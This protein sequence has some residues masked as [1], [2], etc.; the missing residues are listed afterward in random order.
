MA[1]ATSRPG[2]LIRALLLIAACAALSAAADAG[3][4]RVAVAANFTD[5]AT[6]IGRHFEAATGHRAVYSFGSTGQ[7][8]AQITQGAPFDVFMAADR[9]RPARLEDEGL[10][11]PGS[12][13]TYATGRL[14]LYSRDAGL[15]AGA[16]T[17]R[18]DA[19]SRLAVAN[20]ATAPYGAA[21]VAVMKALNVHG[22]LAGRIVQGTNIAQAYQFVAT[23][24][25]DAGFI[26]LSQVI[27][28]DRGSR[29]I[30]PEHLHAPIAQ[31]AV[32][33][34]HGL[35]SPAAR[36]FIAFLKGPQA[37]AVKRDYGYGTGD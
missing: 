33:L 27:H 31:D 6:Q 19:L 9:A 30:V 18:G 22:R 28:H 34:G 11:Q 21:A 36:A 2:G 10:A 37:D 4:V 3:R 12:R 29:W 1:D 13:F 25:A 26:A 24:N 32:L 8:Y 15:V 23:G 35:E 20:P 7:L 17:L 14:V 5:A 16:A